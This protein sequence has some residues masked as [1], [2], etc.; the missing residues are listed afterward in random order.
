M[1]NTILKGTYS[2]TFVADGFSLSTNHYGY[3]E[4][5]AIDNAIRYMK[6]HYG[7]E[8]ENVSNDIDIEFLD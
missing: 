3:S 5:D 7:Y 6:D 4:Q 1:E 2:V 8:M